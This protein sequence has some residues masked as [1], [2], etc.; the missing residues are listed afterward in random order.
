M[1]MTDLLT[2]EDSTMVSSL[3]NSHYIAKVN[4]SR[5]ESCYCCRFQTKIEYPFPWK[6]APLFLSNLYT[7]AKGTTELVHT[8][9]WKLVP[10]ISKVCR[11]SKNPSISPGH[12][13]CCWLQWGLNGSAKSWSVHL[14]PTA[15][16]IVHGGEGK[17]G[18]M[19]SSP[20]IRFTLRTSC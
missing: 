12:C 8:G 6:V 2:L 18:E 10:K 20:M 16:G 17:W 15:A 3:E 14:D 11:T 13:S 4:S 5:I 9:S 1:R 7:S 19:P